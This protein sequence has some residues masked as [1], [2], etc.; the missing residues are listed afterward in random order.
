MKIPIFYTK[1]GHLYELIMIMETCI[2]Y[3]LS[4]YNYRV[5]EYNIS[6]YIQIMGSILVTSI[7]NFPMWP[8]FLLQF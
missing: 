2:F 7:I 8:I 5:D 6:M 4:Y 1:F 3:S